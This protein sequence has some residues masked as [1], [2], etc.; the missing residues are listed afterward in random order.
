MSSSALTVSASIQF[1]SVPH[2][3]DYQPWNNDGYTSSNTPSDCLSLSV[4]F[5]PFFIMSFAG[6]STVTK[7]L[8]KIPRGK[9]QELQG[10]IF[11][12]IPI[13]NVRTGAKELRRPNNGFY[14]KRYYIENID[15]AARLVSTTLIRCLSASFIYNFFLTL[16][17]ISRRNRDS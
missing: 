6:L 12:Q 3:T 2:D 15:K 10:D 13:L 16:S 1:S 9:I 11:G 17:K 7:I 4:L 8:A 5:P 14:I